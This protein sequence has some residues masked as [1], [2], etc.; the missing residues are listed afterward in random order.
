M[1]LASLGRSSQSSTQF[2]SLIDEVATLSSE[3]RTLRKKSAADITQLHELAEKLE[4]A[5]E[6][7]KTLIEAIEV[8]SANNSSLSQAVESMRVEILGVAI[9]SSALDVDISKLE[10]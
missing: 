3:L 1:R 5:R 6:K 4:G 8:E 9:E 2:Q 10:R 7:R